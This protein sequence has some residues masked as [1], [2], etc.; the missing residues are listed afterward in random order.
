MTLPLDLRSRHQKKKR[1]YGSKHFQIV[2]S[3]TVNW[4]SQ[5][6]GF[7][8][9]VGHVQGTFLGKCFLGEYFFVG[10]EYRKH[11]SH[12]G[13]SCERFHV[14]EGSSVAGHS[15]IEGRRKKHQ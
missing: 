4:K 2:D 15:G 9:L 10:R 1:K 3:A 8:L 7:L 6:A 12:P 5:T 11:D 13:K 14:I